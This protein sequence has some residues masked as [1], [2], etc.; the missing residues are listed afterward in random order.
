M[1]SFEDQYLLDIIRYN[2]SILISLQ[3]D[4]KIIQKFMSQYLISITDAML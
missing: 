2:I 3:I 4:S 1:N